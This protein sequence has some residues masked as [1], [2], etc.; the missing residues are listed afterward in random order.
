MA[1]RIEKAPRAGARCHECTA[2]IARGDWR[3]GRA[4]YHTQWFHLRCAER[5]VPKAFAPFA[6]KAA[7]LLAATP[8]EKKM[9]PRLTKTPGVTNTPESLAVL[10]DA[11][12]A[13]GDLVWATLIRLR[14]AEQHVEAIA[15]YEEHAAALT[16]DLN[17]LWIDWRDGVIVRATLDG[18]G[19]ALELRVRELLELRTASR[20]EELHLTGEITPALVQL[21]SQELPPTVRWLTLATFSAARS[22]MSA[23]PPRPPPT[24]PMQWSALELPNVK[25]LRLVGGSAMC[26]GALDAKLPALQELALTTPRPLSTD[27]LDQLV[28]SSLLRQLTRL[29]FDDISPMHQTL[30]DTGLERLLEHQQAL[31]HLRAIWL[32]LAGR[33]LQPAVARDVKRVFGARIKRAAEAIAARTDYALGETFDAFEVEL[34]L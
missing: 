3:F 2:F 24:S 19:K 20:L 29:D 15:W 21:L 27:E 25:S 10:S 23:K 5:A 7:P 4:G 34:P 31:A 30:A 6:A 16:G 9:A 1:W 13:E 11:L 14:L 12:E 26:L 28:E 33:K 18:K 17:P 8:I 32:D 22:Q